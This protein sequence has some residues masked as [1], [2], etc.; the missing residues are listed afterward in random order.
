VGIEQVFP[1]SVDL[2]SRKFIDIP[3]IQEIPGSNNSTDLA[4]DA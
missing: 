4:P 1:E 2:L 3:E